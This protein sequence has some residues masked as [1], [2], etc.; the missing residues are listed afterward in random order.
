METAK[1][2]N[3]KAL[4][5]LHGAMLAG[6]LLFSIVSVFIKTTGRLQPVDAGVGKI[7]QVIALLLAGASAGAGFFLFNRRMQS[8]ND[9]ANAKERMNIY[10]AAAIIRWALIEA[11]VL[12]IIISFMLTG[13]YAFLGLAIVLMGIFA[14]TAPLKNKIAQQLQLNNNEVAKLEGQSE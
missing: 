4:Q 3:F 11:P 9:T 10:R 14:S 13:N 1:A 6:M 12:F 2:N 7:L 8:I 5:I